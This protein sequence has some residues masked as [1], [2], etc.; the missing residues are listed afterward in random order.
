MTGH[1]Q[2]DPPGDVLPSRR[3]G[4]SGGGLERLEEE[5]YGAA[6]SAVRS[7]RRRR[8]GETTGHDDP[9]VGAAPGGGT[10]FGFAS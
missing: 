2:G 6:E 3:P 8:R 7:F 10:A 1:R 9:G 5:G 4:L